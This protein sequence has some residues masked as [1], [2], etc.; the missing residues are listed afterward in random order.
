MSLGAPV[1]FP[2]GLGAWRSVSITSRG[3]PSWLLRA[4]V[5]YKDTQRFL[6][7]RLFT[8][9]AMLSSGV[10][11][12]PIRARQATPLAS[13]CTPWLRAL[14]EAREQRRLPQAGPLS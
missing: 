3:S 1:P 6:S 14:P 8:L 7:N 9:S 5:S 13:A 10:A 11:W 12:Q 2:Y 4:A